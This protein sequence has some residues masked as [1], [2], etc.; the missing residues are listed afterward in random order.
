MLDFYWC[1]LGLG[2]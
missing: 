1:R 2:R